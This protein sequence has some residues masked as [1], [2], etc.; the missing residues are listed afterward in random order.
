MA[1]PMLPPARY[2]TEDVSFRFLL[3]GAAAVLTLILLCTFAVIWLYP[4]VVQDR[5]LPSALPVY[6]APRLQADP[7]ADLERFESQELARLNSVGWIN[8]S[9]GI[10]HIPIDAAMRRIVGQGIPDWPAPAGGK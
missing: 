2:E 7:H 1:E 10:A 5:R 4:G 9:L 8:R 3:C 6:P